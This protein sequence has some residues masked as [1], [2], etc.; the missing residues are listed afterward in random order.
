MFSGSCILLVYIVYIVYNIAMFSGACI[1]IVYI[2]YIVYNIAMFSGAVVAREYGLPC[3]IGAQGATSFFQTEKK[4]SRLELSLWTEMLVSESEQLEERLLGLDRSTLQV[5]KIL[6]YLSSVEPHSSCDTGLVGY[7]ERQLVPPHEFSGEI[8]PSKLALCGKWVFY[9][10]FH[11]IA[12][13]QQP[14]RLQGDLVLLVGSAG[15]I[16]KIKPEAASNQAA[17]EGN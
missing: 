12:V 7:S 6:I 3:I 13:Y 17:S 9:A 16:D 2:V 11:C 14:Q 5:F 8:S 15:T 4:P 10:V 1:L